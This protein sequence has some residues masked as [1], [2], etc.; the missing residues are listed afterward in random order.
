MEPRWSSSGRCRG[1]WCGTVRLRSAAGGPRQPELTAAC[2]GFR[3]VLGAKVI[4][5][6]P[7]GPEAKG[8]IERLDDYL[9]R[10]FLPGR[11]FTSPLNS[12]LSFMYGWESP[13]AAG[14][15][16]WGCAPVDRIGADRAAMLP[17]RAPGA[18]RHRQ[19]MG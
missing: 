3:G 16:P 19:P 14:S 4:I 2:Q 15:G 8:I 13:I 1:C 12:T 6:K 5:C 17:S 7:A 18:V 9:A 10:S 11:S